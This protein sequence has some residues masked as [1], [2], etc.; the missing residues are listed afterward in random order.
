MAIVTSIPTIVSIVKEVI[1]V[2]HNVKNPQ[3]KKIVLKS[4]HRDIT[5]ALKRHQ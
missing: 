5:F 1:Q 2:V 4:L 3:M